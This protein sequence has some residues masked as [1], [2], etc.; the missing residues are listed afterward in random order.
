NNKIKS[1][2][3]QTINDGAATFILN[4]NNLSQG[5]LQLTVFNS[6]RQPVCERMIFI[7]PQSLQLNLTADKEMYDTRSEVQL[8]ITANDNADL[9]MAVYLLD[10]LQGEDDNNILN[11][12]W[13]T[14]ELKGRV[15][16]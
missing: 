6:D 10:S 8:D 4:K 11:Y 14:S 12:L 13:L 3:M 2:L 7:K 16:F 9:S 5:I 1:A 15:E